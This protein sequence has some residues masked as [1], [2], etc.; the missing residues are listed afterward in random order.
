MHLKGYLSIHASFVGFQN[1]FTNIFIMFDDECFKNLAPFFQKRFSYGNEMHHQQGGDP[2]YDHHVSPHHSQ[3][4]LPNT[5]P[6]VQQPLP[7]TTM[8]S[9][10]AALQRLSASIDVTA[11]PASRSNRYAKKNMRKEK[12][13]TTIF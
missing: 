12:V 7:A 11:I 9:S 13:D 6:H 2:G 4:Y 1:L 5:S 8:A 10:V 3:S